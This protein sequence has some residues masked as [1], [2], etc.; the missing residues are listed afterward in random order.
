MPHTHND[1]SAKKRKT[2]RKSITLYRSSSGRVRR[3][4][5]T[6]SSE[7]K[8]SNHSYQLDR[9]SHQRLWRDTHW[10]EDLQKAFDAGKL[11][12]EAIL[13]K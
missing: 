4:K 9:H 5:Q 11:M 2:G 7:P 1:L 3:L 8:F 6:I 12:A 13:A 10:E